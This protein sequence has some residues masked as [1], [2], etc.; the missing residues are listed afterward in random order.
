MQTVRILNSRSGRNVQIG[1][2]SAMSMIT[3][4]FLGLVT[5]VYVQGTRRLNGGV[6][7]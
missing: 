2:A 7:G 1:Y 4:V 3:A 5:I 6:K